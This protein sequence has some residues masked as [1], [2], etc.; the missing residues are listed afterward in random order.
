ME[1]N[2]DPAA[3]PGALSAGALSPFPAMPAPSVS[4]LMAVFNG[5]PLLE[6]S[7]RSV[8]GQTFRDWEMVVVDDAST[9]GTRALVESWSLKDP[10]IRLIGNGRNKGQ[11]PCLNQGLRECRGVWV[12]RQD[13]DDLSHPER[14]GAQ[15]SLLGRHSE[16]VLLGTQGILVDADGKRVGLLDV[17]CDPEGIAWSFPFL[18]PFLH[19]SVVFHRETVTAA[20]GYDEN[21]HIAQDYDLWARLAA[22]GRT[23]NLPARLVSYRHAETSLSKTGREVAFEE[24]D[25]VSTREAQRLLGRAWTGDEARLA[26]DFRRGLAASERQDFWKMVE[27]LENERGRRLPRC[28]RAAWHLRVAGSARSVAPVEMTAAF[29]A[30]P[31]FS[32]RWVRDRWLSP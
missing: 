19:T 10:R 23:A 6:D 15:I 21:F 20:G 8:V 13:A 7:I 16:T 5:G 11:T 30:A 17:P 12:A 3:R 25:R 4:V 24:A 27:R 22:S 31:G 18:N 14:L 26:G 9:D 2:P 28:L 32:A 1:K 29:R